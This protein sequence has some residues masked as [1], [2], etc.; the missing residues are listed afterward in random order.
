MNNMLGD[1][2]ETEWI[3]NARTLSI[4][5][6][7]NSYI[8]EIEEITGHYEST[9]SIRELLVELLKIYLGN[10]AYPKLDGV[11]KASDFFGQIKINSMGGNYE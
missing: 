6:V 5:E 10:V 8:N 1:V 7:L 2:V 4:E 3:R 9:E 11:L